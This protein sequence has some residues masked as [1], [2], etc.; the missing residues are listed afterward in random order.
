MWEGENEKPCAM[1][2]HLIWCKMQD[3][4]Q[5]FHCL[6]I[7]IWFSQGTALH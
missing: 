7:N 6:H 2:S 1:T 3:K 4:L 5:R